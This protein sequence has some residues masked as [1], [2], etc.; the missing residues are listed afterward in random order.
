MNMEQI[1]EE[2]NMLQ[3][4]RDNHGDTPPTPNTSLKQIIGPLIEEVKQLRE[5]FHMDYAKLDNC[6][7]FIGQ[8]KAF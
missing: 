5:T 7:V 3:E 6:Y 4:A 8:I 2:N 1:R